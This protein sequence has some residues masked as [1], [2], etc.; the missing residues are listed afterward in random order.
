MISTQVDAK[1]HRR[2]VRCVDYGLIIVL[3]L[4]YRVPM[5][6]IAEDI[7]VIRLLD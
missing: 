5:N 7:I 2:M 4:S 3:Y 6:G 1:R